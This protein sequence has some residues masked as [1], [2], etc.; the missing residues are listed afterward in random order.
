V[1]APFASEAAHI[2]EIG[3]LSP[4]DIA[5]ATGASETAV[6]VWLRDE[7]S[8]SRVHA[9]RLV[10]LSSLVERL[11]RVMQPAYVP[12][13]G[14]AE[15]SRL[16]AE[17]CRKAHDAGYAWPA[18]KSAGEQPYELRPGTGRRGPDVLWHAFDAAVAQLTR[19][20]ATVDLLGVADAYDAF[21]SACDAL[22]AAVDAEEAA[23]RGSLAARAG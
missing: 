13:A 12:L 15:A 5:R 3:H 21:A 9:Q 8:P 20:A 17:I 14:L 7:R 23:G 2:Q 1:A 6:R 11:V 10:E 18:A 4:S 16:E 19:A 22:S